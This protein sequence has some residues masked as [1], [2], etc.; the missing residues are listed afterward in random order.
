MNNIQQI[1]KTL[2]HVAS[3]K[4]TIFRGEN[5]NFGD[6]TSNLHRELREQYG[7]TNP[8]SAYD[9][10]VLEQLI[11][12]DCKRYLNKPTETNEV[13]WEIQHYGGL[14]NLIDFTSDFLIA[15]YFACEK[16]L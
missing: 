3:S 11:A 6:V 1:I 16:F 4:P 13:L 7:S 2:E 14:T 5:E 8:L 15:L 12:D 10:L 9:L